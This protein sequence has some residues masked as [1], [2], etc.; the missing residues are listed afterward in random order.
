VLGEAAHPLAEHAC[1]GIGGGRGFEA[2]I[3]A[4][5]MVGACTEAAAATARVV[6][7]ALA[8]P[9]TLGAAFAGATQVLLVSSN[10]AADGGDPLAQHRAAIDAAVPKSS[11]VAGCQTPSWRFRSASTEP[12]ERANFRR[13]TPRSSGC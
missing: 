12:R 9:E 1:A 7:A 6:A 11:G 4:D 3:A 8:A 13:S 2:L 5:D 10:A